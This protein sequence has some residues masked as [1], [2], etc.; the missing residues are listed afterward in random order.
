M[1]AGSPP[2]VWHMYYSFISWITQSSTAYYICFVSSHF[3]DFSWSVTPP[4]L[5]FH[6]SYPKGILYCKLVFGLQSSLGT[7]IIPF[8]FVG[9]IFRNLLLQ[10]LHK[11]LGPPPVILSCLTH[12]LPRQ[13]SSRLLTVSGVHH[14]GRLVFR[15][16]NWPTYSLVTSYD[17]PWL[18]RTLF[19]WNF[20]TLQ[21]KSF[22]GQPSSMKERDF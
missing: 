14:S 7:S 15:N 17:G 8:S 2:L 13:Q 11:L 20:L 10:K 9:H 16:R 21:N 18:L 5:K 6:Q 22:R 19:L 12:S 1:N 4:S 3:P